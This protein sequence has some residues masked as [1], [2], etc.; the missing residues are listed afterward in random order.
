MTEIPVL[1]NS[2]FLNVQPLRKDQSG[3][4]FGA[5][6]VGYRALPDG[7][8]GP[9]EKQNLI[10]NNEDI[11]LIVDDINVEF[12]KFNEI[13]ALLSQCCKRK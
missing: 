2:I 8:K 6:F 9:A 1:A 7:S 12:Q 10:R 4:R 5:K 13:I 3:N 11:I